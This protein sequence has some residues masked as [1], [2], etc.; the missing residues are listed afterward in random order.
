MAKLPTTIA[1]LK[2]ANNKLVERIK[3]LEDEYK[4]DEFRIKAYLVMQLDYEVRL[5]NLKEYL[6]HKNPK[7]L[8]DFFM[9]MHK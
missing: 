1:E 2:K 3:E 6:M 5:F 8:R 4:M 7:L 9:E